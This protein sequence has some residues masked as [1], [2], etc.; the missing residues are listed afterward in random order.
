MAIPATAIATIA[1]IKTLGR[2]EDVVRLDEVGAAI[3]TV[4]EAFDF[5]SQRRQS[6]A[7]KDQL[8]IT[9]VAR[10][11]VFVFKSNL[12]RTANAGMMLCPMICS[13]CSASMPE[14]SGFCPACGRAVAGDADSEADIAGVEPL[15]RDAFLGAAAYFT[16]VPAVIFLAVPAIR[17]KRYVRF[18]SWQSILFAVSTVIIAVL[19]RLAFAVLAVFP[20]LGFLLAWLVAGLVSLAIVFLWVAIVIKAALG[21]AYEVPFLG[22]WAYRLTD[23]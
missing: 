14:I 20:F 6:Q 10:A 16:I 22:I 12:A 7:A 8:C 15:S 17:H 19:T 21:D 11:V 18:H 5:R 13:Y 23:R 4:M 2:L 9:S 1:K 3:S